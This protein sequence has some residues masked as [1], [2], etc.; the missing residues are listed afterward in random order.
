VQ[1]ADG[2]AACERGV[3]GARFAA[4]A[5][6]TR[7]RDRVDI[8]IERFDARD[9]GIEQFNSG[10]FRASNS[11]RNATALWRVSSWRSLIGR[12][13]KRSCNRAPM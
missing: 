13:F 10:D 2:I 5:F 12:S 11:A 4:C 6:E 7:R 3:G 8:R 9:A 1:Y